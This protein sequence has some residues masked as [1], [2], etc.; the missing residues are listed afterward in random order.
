MNPKNFG[1]ALGTVAGGFWFLGMTISLLTGIGKGT[2]T[3]IGMLHPYFSYSWTGMAI[4]TV[5]HLVAGFVLGYA[6]A[7]IY[8]KVSK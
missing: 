2:L 6:I 7:W 5:E 3:G 8:N 1:I 4:I